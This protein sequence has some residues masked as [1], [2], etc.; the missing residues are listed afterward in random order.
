MSD[1]VTLKKNIALYVPRINSDGPLKSEV[2]HFKNLILINFQALDPKFVLALEHRVLKLEG[3]S[4][5][6]RPYICFLKGFYKE[7]LVV[8]AGGRC[9]NLF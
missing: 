2:S 9:I 4:F 6:N 7:T 8:V 3:S 5:G 1:R